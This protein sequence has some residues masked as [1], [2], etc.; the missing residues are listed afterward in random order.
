MLMF[1]DVS[2]VKGAHIKFSFLSTEWVLL[3]YSRHGDIE[4]VLQNWCVDFERHVILTEEKCYLVTLLEKYS[5][6][7]YTKRHCI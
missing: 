5:F 6:I 3:I 7:L 2:V 1:Q 4:P